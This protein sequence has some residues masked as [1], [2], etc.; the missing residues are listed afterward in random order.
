[1]KQYKTLLTIENNCRNDLKTFYNKLSEKIISSYRGNSQL[2]HNKDRLI[3]LIIQPL[4]DYEEEFRNI[5]L[6]YQLQAYNQG[7]SDVKELIDIQGVNLVATKKQLTLDIFSKPKTIIQTK[8]EDYSIIDY[9][10]KPLKNMGVTN[11]KG[12]INLKQHLSQIHKDKKHLIERKPSEK[13]KQLLQTNNMKLSTHTRS[14]IT[15]TIKN[16]LLKSE[17]RGENARTIGKLIQ[18][19]FTKLANYESERLARTEIIK[20]HNMA[21][22]DEITNNEL[23][24]YTQWIST[25]DERTRES[26]VELNGMIIRV[27]DVFPNGCQYP[28]D[29][30]GDAEE[31]VNCR[32][33]IV[34][35]I[36]EIGMIAPPDMTCF[37]ESDFIP[38][39]SN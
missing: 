10:K 5:L 30:N 32:C 14:R 31:V 20:C 26:H 2:Y 39:T 3:N 22:Q 12:F 28:G 29:P 16:I 27:G 33:T 18:E 4:Y 13:V 24:D 15:S 8:M 6:N 1:M 35:Y 7:T 9:L 21:K 37:T 19:Q 25:D 36:P 38:I 23:I 34:P 17:T 11:I